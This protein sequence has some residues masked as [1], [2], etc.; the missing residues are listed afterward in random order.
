MQQQDALHISCR[1]QVSRV[2][3]PKSS[4]WYLFYPTS[5]LV[6]V[7]LMSSFWNQG[8]SFSEPGHSPGTQSQTMCFWAIWAA[9]HSV[10]LLQ[11]GDGK[12]GLTA[13]LVAPSFTATPSAP[14]KPE[15]SVGISSHHLPRH[16]FMYLSSWRCGDCAWIPPYPLPFFWWST[17]YP[18]ESGDRVDA[19][20]VLLKMLYP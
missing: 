9:G 13:G 7:V 17:G 16:F 19:G 15:P 14:P 11:S 5:L 8:H 10:T 6:E 1:I 20:F 2:F 3:F 12:E 4:V 18:D